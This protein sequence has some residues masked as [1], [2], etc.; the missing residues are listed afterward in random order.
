M[1]QVPRPR[2]R[3]FRVGA[4]LGRLAHEAQSPERGEERVVEDVC[5]AWEVLEMGHDGAGEEY[6][7]A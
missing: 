2:A 1:R 6:D 5:I 7:E 3:V 4:V